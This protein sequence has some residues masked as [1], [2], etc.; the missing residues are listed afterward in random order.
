MERSNITHKIFSLA[1]VLLFAI[2][3]A[4]L[5]QIQQNINERLPELRVKNEVVKQGT[6]ENAQV[7]VKLRGDQTI[8]GFISRISDDGFT[9]TDPGTRRETRIAFGAVE[10]VKKIEAL[11]IMNFAAG[12][13]ETAETLDVLFEAVFC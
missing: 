7:V 11:A 12:L 3:Q 13:I 8:E 4:M 9:V 2:N 6:G 1:V 10:Q 5:I